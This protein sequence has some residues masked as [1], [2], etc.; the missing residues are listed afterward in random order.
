MSL[1]TITSVTEGSMFNVSVELATSGTLACEL[2]VTLV[3]T[4][5]TA[6]GKKLSI[7][8]CQ[9]IKIAYTYIPYTFCSFL[10]DND[11]SLLVNDSNPFDVTFAV[12]S[13]DGTVETAMIT[14]VED[15]AAEGDHEF[16]VS[17]QSTSLPA[18]FRMSSIVATIM[19]DDCKSTL[20]LELIVVVLF[21]IIPVV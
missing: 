8:W 4:P 18:M 10:T 17:I 21:K 5:G 15:A 2:V 6:T 12:G 1:Q 20:K 19:D 13:G 3:A 14:A 9:I 16:T 7:H 11:Y